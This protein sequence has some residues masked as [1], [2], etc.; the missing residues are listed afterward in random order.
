MTSYNRREKTLKALRALHEQMLPADVEVDTYLFDDASKDRT[1]E[2]VRLQFPQVRILRGDGKHFWNRGMRVAWEEAFGEGYD[3]YLLLNDDTVLYRDALITLLDTAQY[4][5]NRAIVVGSIQDPETKV[6]TYGGLKRIGWWHPLRFVLVPPSTNPVEC[7]TMNGNCVLIP[8]TIAQQ[9]G[10]LDP[11]FTHSM[12]DIDYGL[13][14]RRNGFAIVIAPGYLG[15]CSRNPVKG[16]WSDPTLP[17]GCRWQLVNSPKGRPPREY[18]VLAR[19]HG[20]L[21]WPLYWIMP[22]VGILVS[23]LMVAIRRRRIEL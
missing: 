18:M 14:A 11:A 4:Y 15:T 17:L 1:A 16:T 23:S 21:L 10:N 13:R 7:E 3:Y 20:G 12:G 2:A 9:I 6:H 19:R 5:A 8:H 22:Y